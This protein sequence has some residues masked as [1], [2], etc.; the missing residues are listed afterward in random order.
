MKSTRLLGVLAALAL[1]TTANAAHEVK[2]N[3]VLI[4]ADDIGISG[5]SGYGDPHKT[6]HIDALAKEG[7]RFEYCF[8]APL[9][10]PSRALLMT[11]RY[12]F[13]TGVLNNK[14]AGKMTPK[15][16]TIIAKTLKDAG[17][18]TGF[19]GKWHQL[20]HMETAEEGKAWGFD[21]FLTWNGKDDGERYW[22]PHYNKNGKTLV[23]GD[24]DYG[25]DMLHEFAVDFITRRKDRPFFFYYPMVSVHDPILRT[26]DTPQSGKNLFADNVAYMD[27]LVGK[28]IAELD[29]LKLREKTLIVFLSDNGTVGGGQ[30]DGRKVDGGKGTMKEG[31]SRVPCVV[32]WKGTTPAGVVSKDLIDFSDFHPTLAKA[33]AKLPAGMIIDGRSFAAQLRGQKGKPREWVYVEL[34]RQR[35]VRDARWKLTGDGILSDMQEAPFGELTVEPGKED[36]EAAAARK[37]LQAVLGQLK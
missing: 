17:Y 28:L 12:G 20:Q 23:G 35:Y 3:I 26:P 5:F 1:G 25:P 10:A 14:S 4:M 36:A 16:E 22:A 2:P 21:E 15:T 34:G 30:V 37:R 6:P 24:K 31:G 13:R 9:C 19:A 8:A 11:G 27:K 32:S 18:V 7:T 29:Q 33:G